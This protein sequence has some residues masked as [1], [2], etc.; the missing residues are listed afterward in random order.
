[1]NTQELAHEILQEA[2]DVYE[3]TGW[4]K[5]ELVNSDDERCLQG[6]ISIGILTHCRVEMD[7]YRWQL[8]DEYPEYLA[9]HVEASEQLA[10]LLAMEN[11]ARVAWEQLEYSDSFDEDDEVGSRSIGQ[12]GDI[13]VDFNDAEATTREDILLALDKAIANT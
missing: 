3:K 10:I 1:M 12:I 4:C 11:L 6:A 2:R 8:H 7:M 5:R 9:R 13:I